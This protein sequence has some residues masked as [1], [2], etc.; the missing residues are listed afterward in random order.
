M[1]AARWHIYARYVLLL[2]NGP[3]HLVKTDKDRTGL[4]EKGGSLRSTLHPGQAISE[5]R[6]RH[7]DLLFWYFRVGGGVIRRSVPPTK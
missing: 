5:G 7:E 3:G 2:L 1:P 4:Q 6:G